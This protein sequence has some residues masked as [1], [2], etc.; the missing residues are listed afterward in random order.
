[1]TILLTLIPALAWG[2][3]PL[4]VARINGKPINQIFG[5]A[6]GTLIVS[7]FVVLFLQPNVDLKSFIM[8]A[9]AGA[10][11]I[12][13]QLGQ[14]SGYK[15]IGVSQTMPIST[16]LQLIGT[17]LIGVIL[18][19]EWASTSA[20]ILGFLGIILLIIGS[21][22]TAITDKADLPS[23]G[24]AARTKTI[25]MLILTTIGFLV[26][27]A[28]PKAMSDSGLAIF[29]PESVGMI[30]MV[31]V[32]ILFT[33]QPHVLKEKASWQSVIAGFIFSIAAITYILSVKVN[34]VNLAF[35]ISQLSVVIS[36]LGG[37]I[38]LHESKSKRELTF[39]IIGLILIVG[40]AITTTVI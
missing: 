32:Y 3:L 17:S 5:T 39:T 23:G 37:M 13:G 28:I 12:V 18:F 14:Y 4:A 34:G 2:I 24:T 35:V 15:A 16:G 40:G 1:M 30:I 8:A 22:L 27:N 38:F 36:T 9:L 7:L 11:W 26:Y 6:V 25:I 21:S 19:G 31:L 33:K 29:F 20:K 10:F